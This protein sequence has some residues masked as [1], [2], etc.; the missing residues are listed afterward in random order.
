MRTG[1][2]IP[3]IPDKSPPVVELEP[4]TA[5]PKP[6]IPPILTK[7]ALCESGN[8]HFDA[9]GVKRGKVNPLDIGRFQINLFYHE[10][11]AKEMGLDLFDE[12]D[13]E[14]YALY[15]YEKQGTRPWNPSRHCWEQSQQG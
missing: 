14:E 3:L 11:Q 13:N 5:N 7:I 15:L 4:V 9:N 6:E 1:R 2:T 12:N 8:S 10:A